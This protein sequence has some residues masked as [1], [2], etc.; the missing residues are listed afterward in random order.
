MIADNKENRQSD[1]NLLQFSAEQISKFTRRLEEGYDFYDP[2]YICWL[3][4]YHPECLQS[5]TAL[6]KDV[7]A[8]RYTLACA[9]DFVCILLPHYTN[10]TP[11]H[12]DRWTLCY[13]CLICY[14]IWLNHQQGL[15]R[16]LTHML[17]LLHLKS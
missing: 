5:Y 4:Q 16:P 3:E 8:D 9:E 17:L 14:F 1:A 13:D 12:W 6:H 2:V 7:P 10:R 11:M 15:E